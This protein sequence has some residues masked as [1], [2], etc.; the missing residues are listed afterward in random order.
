MLP[1]RL[2]GAESLQ[3][4]RCLPS[5]H[6]GKRL[7]AEGS[8]GESAA[9]RGGNCAPRPASTP[10][11]ATNSSLSFPSAHSLSSFAALPFFA[12]SL[13]ASPLLLQKRSLSLPFSLSLSF[14]SLLSHPPPS[15]RTPGLLAGLSKIS[16]PSNAGL[17]VTSYFIQLEGI[18]AIKSKRSWQA[19]VKLSPHGPQPRSPPS[20]FFFFL[21]TE[22][23]P[24]FHPNLACSKSCWLSFLHPLLGQK[25]PAIDASNLTKLGW[26]AGGEGG[27]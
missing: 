20:L 14:S 5:E 24:V 3:S 7:I 19:P 17:P 12:V 10:H 15:I 18:K 2:K 23:A 26:G 1:R 9:R 25:K 16:T 13:P 4:S 8:E 6:H 22:A 11:P 27:M 21:P